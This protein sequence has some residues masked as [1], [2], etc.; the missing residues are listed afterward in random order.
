MRLLA[1][2]AALA[3]AAPI[4][5]YTGSAAAEPFQGQSFIFGRSYVPE[6]PWC[7]HNNTSSDRVEEDCSFNSFAACNREAQLNHGFCTQNFAGG[8]VPV[9]HRKGDRLRR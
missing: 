1:L 6:G 3:V 5:L 8:V 2:I 4:G 7:A 9:R